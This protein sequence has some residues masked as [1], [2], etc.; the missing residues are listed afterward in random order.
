M[1]RFNLGKDLAILSLLWVLMIPGAALGQTKV[2][3]PKNKYKVQDDVK[4]GDE[5]SGKVEKEFPILRDVESE[6]YIQRVGARLVNAI[7]REFQQ[8]AFKYRFKIVNTKDINAFALPGGP[9]YINRGLIQ[10]AKNEGEMAGVMAHE[11]SHVALRHGTAQA[12]RQRS[13]KNQ[14]LGGLLVIGGAI[15]GGQ[16]GAQIGAAIFTGTFVLKY[17]RR[18]ETQSDIL[19]ARI[20]ADAGYD[21]RD[22]A[23]MFKTIDSQSKGGRPPEWLSSHPDPN[24][25]FNTINN[26][27]RFL[28]VS[29]NP[30]KIT[31]GF[32]RIKSKLGS[33]PV[34]KSMEEIEKE[35]KN[36]NP[37]NVGN[38]ENVGV[39]SGMSKGKY[40]RN[41]PLPSSRTRIY[42]GGDLFSIR[43]PV[44]WRQFPQQNSIMLAPEGAYGN[45]GITHGALVG[46][47][48]SQQRTLEGAAR[49]Y[50]QTVLKEN[51][52]LR[53]RTGYSRFTLNG[54]RAIA[55][56]LSGRS[57]VTRV[58][59][60]AIIYMTRLRDG[61]LFFIVGVA[62]QRENRLYR[63]AFNRMVRSVRLNRR[64]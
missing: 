7:P 52:Y 50:I 42:N 25:R 63:G 16:T 4:I 38:T 31:R 28:R 27:A 37:D 58:T 23:N 3:L 10:I 32:L 35:R 20:M 62:P 15:F 8:P 19:G 40:S 18:Y 44:N 2:S 21:P 29:S 5:Y 17:S 48:A 33:L 49:E 6:R 46:I 59:E 45:N 54:R 13:A 24:R 57:P 55:I 47:R 30:I 39:D 26:E 53:Q 34:V 61:R 64:V 36:P 22:L 9:M 12:T 51:T 41:I 60:D 43:V 56:R 1:R 11:I 14:I